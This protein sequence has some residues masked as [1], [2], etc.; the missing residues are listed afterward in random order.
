MYTHVGT[1]KLNLLWRSENVFSLARDRIKKCA[2]RP[3][4]R[5]CAHWHNR[6]LSA[7][8]KGFIVRVV[9]NSFDVDHV[10]RL[11]KGYL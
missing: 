7:I 1:F 4:E 3:E 10:I 2:L 9:P 6:A 11:Y 5:L 8:Y